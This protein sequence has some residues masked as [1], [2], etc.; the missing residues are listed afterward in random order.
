MDKIQ[1]IKRLEYDTATKAGVST[2]H[3]LQFLQ[4]YRKTLDYRLK[5]AALNVRFAFRWPR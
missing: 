5:I 4:W 3:R 2:T 1:I